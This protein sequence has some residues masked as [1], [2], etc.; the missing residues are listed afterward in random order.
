MY[1]LMG[2]KD[3]KKNTID[4]KNKQKTLGRYQ[5]A[6]LIIMVATARDS[7]HGSISGAGELNKEGILLTYTT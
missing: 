5:C 7:Q 1:R 2:E 6:V 4:E 3:E